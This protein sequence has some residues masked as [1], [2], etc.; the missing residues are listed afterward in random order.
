MV[1]YEDFIK[2]IK[3]NKEIKLEEKYL[4]GAN[5][6]KLLSNFGIGIPMIL[7]GLYSTY[8][9]TRNGFNLRV[10][11]GIGI[12][13]YGILVLYNILSFRFVIDTKDMKLR[14]KK[15]E[16]DFGNIALCELSKMAAPGGKRLE[17]CL[18]FYTNDKKEIIL[19]LNMKNKLKFVLVIKEV[20]KD[21]FEI[22]EEK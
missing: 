13:A 14:D 20:L 2:K 10:L 11:I 9:G 15:I 4:F 21:K 7:L 6:N 5:I 16:I 17:A 3:E 8:E 12:L 22:I 18:S 19:P 1:F